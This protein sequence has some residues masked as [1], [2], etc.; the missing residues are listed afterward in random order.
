MEG[1]IR[2]DLL[3]VQ[4]ILEVNKVFTDKL[5]QHGKNEWKYG[6]PWTEVLSALKKHLMRFEAGEDYNEEGRLNIAE[7][8]MNALIL[9]E[10]Y[11]I[12]PQGDDRVIAPVNKPIVALDL[13]DTVF[14]FLGSYEK[15]TGIKPSDY[16]NG[17]Y[18]MSKNLDEL[19]NN[20]DFWVNMPVKNIPNFEVDYYVTARSI[21][22]EWTQEAI[23]KNN[24]PKAKIYTLPWNVS[25]I[26]TLKK[27]GIQIFIDD[28]YETYKECLNSGIFCY[29]M[30]AP[31][32][33]H[34]NVGHHRITNLNLKI[35]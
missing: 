3:P 24:L 18:N 13:D 28:K 22:I 16:W 11:S 14:D 20:K 17:D 27:L 8:A 2:Y 34:Y 29:L 4:G 5:K 26:E 21:P 12:Y 9:S 1:K 10:F 31:H 33:R 15:V 6:I 32:N 19:K 30:D 25:K 35:K 7:V 23:Q